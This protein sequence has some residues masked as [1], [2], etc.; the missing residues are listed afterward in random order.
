MA[1]ASDSGARSAVRCAILGPGRTRNGLGPFLARHAERHGMRVVAAAGRDPVRNAAACAVL[2]RELGHEVAVCD[3]LEGLLGRELDA[4]I[5]AAPPAAHRTAL[6]AA[7]ERG[8]H[9]LCEKPFVDVR[10]SGAVAALCEGF[11]AKG[12]VLRENCQWPCVL[13]GFEALWPAWR[14]GPRARVAMRLSPVG[15]GRAMVEDSLSHLLSVIQAVRRFD[16]SSRARA[17]RFSTTSSAAAACD[18]EF[19]VVSA[20]GAVGARLELVRCEQ[21][22]RPAWIE[23]DG[24]RADREVRMS[25]YAMSL[26]AGTRSV[27][28]DDPLGS[29]VYGFATAIRE[30]D[31]ERN[32]AEASAIQ[33]RARLWREVVDAW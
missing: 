28:I 19:D 30:P 33:H 2:E 11:V 27:P 13:P 15:R 23:I 32:R 5:V 8:L 16:A 10:D 7:L 14:A 24:A 17:V 25:D 21:Q 12:L 1:V 18:V 31:V 3:D 20:T 22:P 29:L 4:L 9:V 26:V 6:A